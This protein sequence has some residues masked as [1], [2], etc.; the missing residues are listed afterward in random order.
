M[1]IEQKTTKIVTDFPEILYHATPLS[2]VPKILKQ[3][4]IP[5][6]GNKISFHPERVY[7]AVRDVAL[8]M[9]TKFKAE[10]L[11]DMAILEVNTKGYTLYEDPQYT[12]GAVFVNHPIPPNRIKPLYTLKA[13]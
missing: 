3:G 7:L 9:A 10:M 2:K 5:K 6:A 1:E 12:N 8:K 4:L 11:E 13:D